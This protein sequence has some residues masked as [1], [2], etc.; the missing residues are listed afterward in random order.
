MSTE[1][2]FEDGT[3]YVTRLYAA[4][5]EA[6]FEAWIETSKVQQWWGCAEATE[7]RSEVEPRVGGAYN[8]RM[9]LHGQIEVPGYCEFTE[10]DPPKR[11]AYRSSQP[12]EMDKEMIV[13]VDFVEVDGGTEVRLSHAG[14]PDVSVEGDIELRAI[15]QSGW[16]AA[17]GKLAQLM[18]TGVV[19]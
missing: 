8:H 11:L 10:Y 15:I 3:L 4:P 2:R 17:F 9:T 12:D 7:V 14:I 6:V 13:S 1:I 16:T 5:R 18:E 19:R